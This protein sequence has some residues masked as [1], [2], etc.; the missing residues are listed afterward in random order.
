MPKQS[1]KYVVYFKGLHLRFK[2]PGACLLCIFIVLFY[3]FLDNPLSIIDLQGIVS[4]IEQSDSVI[5]I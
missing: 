2:N 5:Y 4:G 3:F 1:C